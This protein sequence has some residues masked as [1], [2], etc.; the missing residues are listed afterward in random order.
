[1]AYS[2]EGLEAFLFEHSVVK[3]V[4]FDIKWDCNL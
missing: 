1:M 3:S 2:F 4:R